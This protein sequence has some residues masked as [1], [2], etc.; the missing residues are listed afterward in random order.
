M[1]DQEVGN[2]DGVHLDE[3][4]IGAG[5]WLL[6]LIVVPLLGV[7]ALC[8]GGVAVMAPALGVLRTFGID[9]VQMEL[10]NWQVPVLWSIPA[11]LVISV[12]SGAFALGAAVMLR[13]YLA[14]LHSG[15]GAEANV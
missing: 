4:A 2:R 1:M 12:V 9:W 8:F 7:A 14:W 13:S 3:A 5:A 15:F 11:A 10:F 6:S